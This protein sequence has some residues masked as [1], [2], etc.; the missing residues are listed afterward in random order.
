MNGKHVVFGRVVQGMELVRSME[1][2]GT[3]GGK[4]RKRV[5]IADCGE[6]KPLGASKAEATAEA[7]A[8][9]AAKAKAKAKAEAKAK[10]KQEKEAAKAKQVAAAKAKAEAE[11]AARRKQEEME[12]TL[13]ARKPDLDDDES[14]DESESESEVAVS[15]AGGGA[16]AVAGDDDD[17]DS[18]SSDDGSDE[19]EEEAAAAA[20]RPSKKARKEESGKEE[21][22]DKKA[23][24]VALHKSGFF[25]EKTFAELPLS[26]AT[27]KAL[28]DQDFKTMT[29]VQALAIPPLLAGK[30]VLG[31]AK[32]VVCCA[33]L[34][35]SAVAHAQP[36][37][38]L[39]PQPNRTGSGKTLA[40][41]VPVIELLSNVRPCHSL[42]A[43][44]SL[45]PTDSLTHSRTPLPTP[46]TQV[47][48]KAR[49]GTGA[50]II[51][52]VRE[53]ALQVYGVVRDLCAHHG[54]THGCIMGGANRRAEAD[55]LCKGV[56]ILVS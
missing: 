6:V 29:R 41:V 40:F 13:G 50:I 49:N 53:L 38:T 16:G 42:S 8:A 28:A 4:T 36:S 12:A 45:P 31:A 34:V 56:N 43:A 33:L 26:E 25:S 54:L 17:E 51:L 21:S 20:A 22:E 5:V 44:A 37:P 23:E 2:Q 39:A 7:E 55:R 32:Y 1:K 11:A 35:L 14:E 52:P 18:D 24:P 3:S 47:Q 27:K 19:E 30:D 46:R 48:F 15:G 9:A 10:K